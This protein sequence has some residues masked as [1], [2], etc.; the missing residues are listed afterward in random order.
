MAALTTVRLTK[1][2]YTNGEIAF[3][4]KASTK[5]F[6]GAMVDV[7]GINTGYASPM[8]KA[9]GLKCKG[10]AKVTADNTSGANGDIKVIVQLS[11]TPNGT[12]LFKLTNDPGAGA[13]AITD[14]GATVYALDDNTV[15]KTSTA[16]TA[17][18]E[19]VRLDADGGVWIEI[20]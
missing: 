18:G 14:I 3:P 8:T 12:R 9:T 7:S 4:V 11:Q 15:T 5:I 10:I 19:F 16:A 6:A 2:S 1:D 17:V 13:L 20:K